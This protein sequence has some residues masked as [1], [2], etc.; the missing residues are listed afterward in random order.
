MKSFHVQP[1]LLGKQAIQET[2]LQNIGTKTN[3]S[4]ENTQQSL[5]KCL[6]W[7]K[8]VVLKADNVCSS[9]N[10]TLLL[11]SRDKQKDII[12]FALKQFLGI[13]NYKRCLKMDY[14]MRQSGNNTGQTICSSKVFLFTT[15]IVKFQMNKTT[16]KHT[17][18]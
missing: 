16:Q 14:T 11:T 2:I 13:C 6:G 18:G 12:V 10:T 8:I 5:R 1:F 15:C 17:T 9:L 7:L 4:K 3:T